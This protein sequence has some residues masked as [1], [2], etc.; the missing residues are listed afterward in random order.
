[1]KRMLRVVVDPLRLTSYGLS[2]TDVA[3]TLRLVPFDVPA[4][5]F[6]SEDQELIVRAD[7]SVVSASQISDIII[8]DSIRIG[9][10]ANV[11]FGPEDAE[12]YTRLDGQ[13]VI[14][15]G[16][17]RQAKAN[18]VQISDGVHAAVDRINARVNNLELVITDDQAVF[19]RS[20][21]AEVLIT[22]SITIAIVIAT[23]WLFTGTL[24][25]TLV[26]SIAIPVALVGTVAAIWL[27]GFSINILTLLAL[28]LATGLVVDDAIVVLENIQRRRAQGL[29]A[30]AAAVLGTRQVFFA[31]VTTTAVL[32]SVFVPIA[33]LPSTAGRLF[34]EFGVVLAIAVAISS[35]VSLS[36]VPAAA[37]RLPEAGDGNRFNRAAANVGNRLRD[38]YARSLSAMLDRPWIPLIA[39]LIFAGG[40]V[41]LYQGLD[42]VLIPP[43][44]RGVVNVD[45]MG[46]DGT[47][48]GYMDRQTQKIEDILQPLVDSGEAT[49]L[50]TIVG[51]WDPN[52]SRVTVPLVDWDDRKRSQQEIAASV[53]GPLSR[54]PGARVSVSGSNSLNLR[55][56]GGELEVAL[57]GNEY[58]T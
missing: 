51:T 16:V 50:F 41:A 46:P 34:R 45:A 42:R 28:V 30:R 36:L 56:S 1:R 39:A 32:I 58:Y 22:L 26:P 8:R 37:S 20:S 10:V 27:V 13:S 9:D 57:V 5:S 29:G 18:T 43:E 3:T 24:R 7:A 38:F 40:A 49:S 17:I 31:V 33:F 14:G 53:E 48:I 6:R 35:F 23:I 55:R 19:I 54:I 52:R 2:V 44:D 21:I 4:G 12:A 15:L 11:Y 47:G 25:A